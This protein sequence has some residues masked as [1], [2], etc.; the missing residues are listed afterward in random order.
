[1]SFDSRGGTDLQ[2]NVTPL[3]DVIRSAAGH[4]HGDRADPAAGISVNLPYLR[5][6]ARRA[7]A[8]VVNVAANGDVYRTTRG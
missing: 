3:V 1:M 4:L 8:D 5:R 7:D 6:R 2:I